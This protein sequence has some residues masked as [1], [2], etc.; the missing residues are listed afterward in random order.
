MAESDQRSA[1]QRQAQQPTTNTH[2]LQ[3]LTRLM[4]CLLERRRAPVAWVKAGLAVW[5]F[6]PFTA[7]IS[8]RGSGGGAGDVHAA[9][10][11]VPAGRRLEPL[12]AGLCYGLAVHWR[13]LPQ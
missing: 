12:L 4:A 13:L 7:V 8:T 11:A 3:P 5:L 9:G 10:Y 1:D 2:S 6:S